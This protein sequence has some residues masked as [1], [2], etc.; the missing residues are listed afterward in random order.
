MNYKTSDYNTVM[1]T[2]DTYRRKGVAL[3]KAIKNVGFSN[4]PS[5]YTWKARHTTKTTSAPK[6]V[7]KNNV[8]GFYGNVNDVATALISISTRG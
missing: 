5:F 7:A 3:K 2:I 1:D 8:F 4:T 6:F